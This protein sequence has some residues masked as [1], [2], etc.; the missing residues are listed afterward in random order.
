MI[1]IHNLIKIKCKF[2]VK[3]ECHT[4]SENYRSGELSEKIL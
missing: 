1:C 2:F 4:Q 3:L